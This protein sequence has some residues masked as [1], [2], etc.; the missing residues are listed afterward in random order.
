MYIKIFFNYCILVNFILSI[1]RLLETKINFYNKIY[2]PI[3]KIYILILKYIYIKNFQYSS[4]FLVFS[5]FSVE[6]YKFV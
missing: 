4:F 2:I 3:L 5:F 1:F 6:K